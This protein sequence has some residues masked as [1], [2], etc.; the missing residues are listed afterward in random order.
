[1]EKTLE[2][3]SHSLLKLVVVGHGYGKG[4]M[5]ELESVINAIECDT[6]VVATPID[7]GALLKI[8]KP[9]VRVSYSLQEK[10][11]PDLIDVLKPFSENQ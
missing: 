1:M 3:M 4:Q 6:V 7:L 5:N 9:S 2:I 11:R 8:N 10:G